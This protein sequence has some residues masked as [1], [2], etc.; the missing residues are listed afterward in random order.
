MTTSIPTHENGD[1]FDYRYCWVRD[2]YFLANT[3]NQLGISSTLE[4]FLRFLSNIVA[5]FEST[6]HHQP[7][8]SVCGISLERR[9]HYREMH[10]LAGYRKM[11]PVVLG[12]VVKFLTKID[13][14]F[15]IIKFSLKG[16][17]KTTA[18]HVWVLNYGF[19]SSIF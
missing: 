6:E 15:F 9:I 7:I 14:I 1:N 18:P 11:G 5:E 17:R 16:S 19:V 2:A 10:R 13:I 3:L 4:S 8:A 12:C